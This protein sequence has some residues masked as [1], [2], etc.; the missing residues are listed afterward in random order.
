MLNG[1]NANYSFENTR[2]KNAPNVSH[3]ENVRGLVNA[4]SKIREE[5][6]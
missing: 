4:S 2:F 6:K 1:K 5:K 3:E